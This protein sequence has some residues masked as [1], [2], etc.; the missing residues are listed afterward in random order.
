[1]DTVVSPFRH[2]VVVPVGSCDVM[3]IVV[4]PCAIATLGSQRTKPAKKN[5]TIICDDSCEGQ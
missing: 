4:A 2:A 5:A 3:H 1:M